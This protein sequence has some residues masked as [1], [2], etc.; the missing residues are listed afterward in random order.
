ME[1]DFDVYFLSQKSKLLKM[2]LILIFRFTSIPLIR[3]DD[4]IVLRVPLNP[5]QSMN[6]SII[7]FA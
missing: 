3:H 2:F 6:Q 5:S 4:L 7:C 1:W